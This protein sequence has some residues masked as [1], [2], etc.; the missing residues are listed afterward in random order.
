MLGSGILLLSP[1]IALYLGNLSKRQT[2]GIVVGFFF[3][4][5]FAL[6][7]FRRI[8]FEVTLFGLCGFTAVV[9][10]FLG[11]FNQVMCH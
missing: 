1:V 9:V 11:G 10:A 7:M 8:R 4:F 3:L 5:T 2:V 6:C